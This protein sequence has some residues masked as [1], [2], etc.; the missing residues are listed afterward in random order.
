[1]STKETIAQ[2]LKDLRNANKFTQQYISEK[3]GIAQTTYAGYETGKHEPN[4]DALKKL[5][6]LYKTSV[7]YII[8]RY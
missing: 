3:L 7:D 1:M 2:R 4:A 8:G 6:E 5:A